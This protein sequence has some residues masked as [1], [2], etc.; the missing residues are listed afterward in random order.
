MLPKNPYL[1]LI[2]KY[3]NRDWDWNYISAKVPINIIEKYISDYPWSFDGIASNDTLTT[4]FIF[5]N[6]KL[7]EFRLVGVSRKMKF[8]YDYLKKIIAKLGYDGFDYDELS[9]NHSITLDFVEDNIHK[10]NCRLLSR[11]FFS[12]NRKI[13][14]KQHKQILRLCC[15][16]L[17]KLGTGLKRHII[18]NYIYSKT[19]FLI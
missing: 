1:Y 14:R 6:I 11:N 3:P 8:D 15:F 4:K 16:I 10:L 2:Q 9:R 19:E 17:N 12:N 7:F 18:S 5:E 13:T